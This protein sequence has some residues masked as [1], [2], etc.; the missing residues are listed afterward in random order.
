MCSILW[1]ILYNWEALGC[2]FS[3]LSLDS[4]IGNKG[5]KE[6]WRKA[7][8]HPWNLSQES[9]GTLCISFAFLAFGGCGLLYEIDLTGFGGTDLT[10]YGNRPDRFVPKVGTCSGGSLHM[11]RGSSCLFWWFVLFAWAW[12]CLGCVEL[13]PLPK[14]FETCLLQV[15]LL[16]AFSRLSIACWSFFLFVS[17]LFFLFSDYQMCVLSMHS[18]RG[19][20]RTMRGSRTGGW[21]LPVVMSDWQRCVDWFLAKYCM[22]RLRLDSCWCRWRTSAKGHCRWGLQVWRRQ[23]GLVRG[24]RWPAGSSE[25]RMVARTARWSR[26]TIS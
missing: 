26:W 25:G 2:I 7:A 21:S 4:C 12:F 10:G 8:L 16:F 6:R 18:S 3:N 20:L 13:L 22:W 1:W 5:E 24:T 11:C 9:R 17:F 19:R 15:I 14:G 23:V